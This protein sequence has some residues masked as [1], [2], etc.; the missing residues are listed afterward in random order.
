M[1]KQSKFKDFLSSKHFS[2][3]IVNALLIL[4]FQ[5]L[6]KGSF[7]TALN[8]RAIFNGMVI[9]S[10]FA[11]GVGYLMLYGFMDLSVGSTGSLAGALLTYMIMQMNCNV[12]VAIIS[13]LVVGTI[14]GFINALLVNE[15]NFQPFIVTLG[16]SSVS[17][18]L[19]YVLVSSQGMRVESAVLKW[20]GN[21][22]YFNRLLPVTVIIAI[23]FFVIYGIILAKTEFGRTIYLCGGNKEA[24]RLCG[25][26]PKRLSYILF[27]NCGFLSAVCGVLVTARVGTAYATALS[28]YQFTGLTAAMLGGIAFGGGSGDM[29]GCFLGML[30]ISLF[31][32]GTAILSID[33]NIATVFNG[34]LLVVALAIDAINARRTAKNWVKKSLAETSNN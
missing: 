30:I 31:N 27:S 2:L 22:K 33:S 17:S 15:F 29:F 19:A 1:K 23:I 4:L 12:W 7:L 18:G 25:L 28:S 32:T 8:I 11:V 5:I 24:A 16:M 34:I 21:T 13:A 10:F 9:C 3:I 14:F 20:I 26:H 6:S